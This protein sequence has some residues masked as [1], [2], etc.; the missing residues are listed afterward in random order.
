[1]HGM[2]GQLGQG[3]TRDAGCQW[4]LPWQSQCLP[5]H[6]QRL[7]E[8][9]SVRLLTAGSSKA[10]L[11]ESCPDMPPS[12]WQ[13]APHAPAIAAQLLR[14]EGR[15]LGVAEVQPAAG[16]HACRCMSKAG[17]EMYATSDYDVTQDAIPACAQFPV[18]SGA[19]SV[20]I[21]SMRHLCEPQLGPIQTSVSTEG[22]A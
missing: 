2:Y 17:I 15:Q 19:A 12:G 22:V 7:P 11:Q 1:M 13:H 3:Y 6:C 4:R 20:S 21:Q 18:Q 16:G 5:I 10:A 8:L 9:A 14:D